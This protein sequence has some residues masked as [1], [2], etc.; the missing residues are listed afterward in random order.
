ML[1]CD[2]EGSGC[3]RFEGLAP[4][5][6]LQRALVEV[7]QPDSPRGGRGLSFPAPSQSGSV[8]PG[9]LFQAGQDAAEEKDQRGQVAWWCW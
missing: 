4:R 5:P 8:E 6:R 2:V 1:H 9:C 7:G 3:V